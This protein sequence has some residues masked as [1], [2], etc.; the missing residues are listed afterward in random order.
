MFIL[1]SVRRSSVN[2]GTIQR[3]IAIIGIG[4][5]VGVGIS[6]G[7]VISFDDAVDVDGIDLDVDVD[8]LVHID[9]G[10]DVDVN[11]DDDVDV[12]DVFVAS[13]SDDDFTAGFF[14]FFLA[15]DFRALRRRR[16]SV[17]LHVV[18]R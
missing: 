17:L 15:L 18:R 1:D 9:V 8:V 7:I 5:D 6:V 10:V 2:I 14:D 11:I 12:D 13:L 3:D 4:V 16:T